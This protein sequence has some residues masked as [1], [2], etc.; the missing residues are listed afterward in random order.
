M[1][2]GEGRQRGVP[3]PRPVRPRRH[4]AVEERRQDLRLGEEP[5]AASLPAKF[6][7][8]LVR[9]GSVAVRRLA[10]RPRQQAVVPAVLDRQSCRWRPSCTSPASRCR[11]SRRT[12]T[13]R[14]RSPVAR[15]TAT[16]ARRRSTRGLFHTG[17]TGPP[18]GAGEK[19]IYGLTTSIQS[20][21]EG[22]Y[23]RLGPGQ[24]QRYMHALDETMFN[25][26]ATGGTPDEQPGAMPEIFPSPDQGANIDRCWTCRSM[27]MQAW[28]NYGTAWS[29]VHQW[30]GRRPGP[31]SARGRVRAAGAA[32]PDHG[33]RATTS[34]SATVRPTCIATH[35]GTHL[36]HR[37][38]T[39][40]QRRRCAHGD[41]RRHAAARQRTRRRVRARRPRGAQLPGAP[42][43]PWLRGDRARRARAPHAGASTAA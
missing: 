6:D 31:R 32:G 24:Q 5:R 7:Q 12:S 19:V 15:T 14:P 22:N 11:A 42:D 2:A 40:E 20:V 25:E 38:S 27:F 35:A 4:G 16:A 26:P 33:A 41:H 36:P 9:P 18:S 30:L 43:Q 21:G 34:G 13:G 28:G 23:G 10:D 29:V 8:H 17:C 3:D 1:G 39:H 37:S